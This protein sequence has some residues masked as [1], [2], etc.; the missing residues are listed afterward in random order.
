MRND[1]TQTHITQPHC[2]ALNLPPPSTPTTDTTSMLHRSKTTAYLCLFFSK[3]RKILSSH[4]DSSAHSLS[5][6][7]NECGRWGLR[8]R[9]GGPGFPEGL[10]LSLPLFSCKNCQSLTSAVGLLIGSAAT[11]RSLI[12]HRAQCAIR[13]S[14]LPSLLHTG[15]AAMQRRLPVPG[16]CCQW[17]EPPLARRSRT[18]RP[19]P[20]LPFVGC[21]S[22]GAVHSTHIGFPPSPR[23]WALHSVHFA[24]TRSS[25]S[26]SPSL[27]LS[28]SFPLCA[29]KAHTRARAHTHTE[30]ETDLL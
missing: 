12:G 16:C 1:Q 19:L 2:K 17:A 8:G 26:L 21:A 20:P 27:S 4:A 15:N 18:R 6:I 3:K 9:D 11:R 23:L 14:L 10:L 5:S 25:R 28:L 7:C 24:Q 30:Q 13:A 22:W 29:E